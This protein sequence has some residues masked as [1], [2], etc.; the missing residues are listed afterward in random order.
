MT[1]RGLV[2]SFLTI[3]SGEKRN[4]GRTCRLLSKTYKMKKPTLLGRCSTV[5]VFPLLDGYETIPAPTAE[6]MTALSDG[7][8]ASPH[9][10]EIRAILQPKYHC[11]IL[12]IGKRV[13][14]MNFLSVHFVRIDKGAAS[15]S[16]FG[17]EA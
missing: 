15:S 14:K 16:V 12:V 10:L 9:L 11:P 1:D 13:I 4:S 6:Y 2:S 5:D 7:L 3:K 8:S 17:E